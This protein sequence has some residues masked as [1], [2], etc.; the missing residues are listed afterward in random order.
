MFRRPVF[1][2]FGIAG[3]LLLAQFP[4]F[5]QQYTQR[6]GGRLDEV[7]RQVAAL[8]TRAAEADKDSR[9]Y[10]AGFLENPDADVRREGRALAALPR[11]E[12]RLRQAYEALTGAGRG[13]RAKSFVE[14][15]DWDIAQTTAAAYAPAMP[16]TAESAVYAG[17]GFGTGAVLFWTFFGLRR[18]PRGKTERAS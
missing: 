18:K 5:F 15:F 12:L 16:V 7:T 2:L 11:R 6:L 14:H 1:L 17:A 13:W 10:V 8:E 4:E 3:A 9:S